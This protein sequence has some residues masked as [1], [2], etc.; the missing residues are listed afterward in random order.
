[1]YRKENFSYKCS[2]HGENQ[3]ALWRTGKMIKESQNF[4]H[5]PG[6]RENDFIRP[7]VLKEDF[8]LIVLLVLPS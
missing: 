1:M 4:S 7:T 8:T 2:E 5:S 3:K 6:F